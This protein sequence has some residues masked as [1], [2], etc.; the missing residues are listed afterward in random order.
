MAVTGVATLLVLLFVVTLAIQVLALVDAARRPDADLATRG[1]KTLWLVLL[2][3]ALV[4]PGGFLLGLIYLLA[5][6][7]RRPTR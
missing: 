2:A 4:I 6:R 5:I 1:G 3:V 7:P